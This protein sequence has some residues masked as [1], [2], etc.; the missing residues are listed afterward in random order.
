LAKKDLH[1]LL[2]QQV[3]EKDYHTCNGK[4]PDTSFRSEHNHLRLMHGVITIALCKEVQTFP[5]NTFLTSRKSGKIR[6]S[7]SS[8]FLRRLTDS[9]TAFA[10]AVPSG[11]MYSK[12]VFSSVPDKIIN[13]KK[14][15]VCKRYG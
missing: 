8:N 12:F 4:N 15:E 9:R 5:C 6:F 7:D 14:I 13:T 11:A 2:L 1:Q 10:F 3:S